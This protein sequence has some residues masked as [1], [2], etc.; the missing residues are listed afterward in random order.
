MKN[1][2]LAM[3]LVISIGL[4]AD[5][6]QPAG[7]GTDI[8]PY[9]IETLD[10][11]LWVSTNDTSWSAYF[12]QTTDI[13][14]S[15]TSGWNNGVGFNR[16]GLHVSN[17]FTGNYDGQG[18]IID[19]LFINSSTTTNCGLFGYTVGAEI[20]NLGVTNIDFTVNDRSGGIV[21]ILLVHQYT[22]A[23]Q[24]ELSAEILLPED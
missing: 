16:I 1:L 6:V 24:P 22:T 3:L 4:F 14:A 7:A 23:I 18:N 2:F 9:Q 8:D 5:G 17:S 13:D 15:A 10:N 19:N 12:I 11:L 20:S 21:D